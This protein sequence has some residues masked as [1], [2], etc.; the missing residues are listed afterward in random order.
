MSITPCPDADRTISRKS[1]HQRSDSGELDVFEAAR[2]FSGYGDVV[3]GYDATTLV[4]KAA[5]AR[6]QEREANSRGGG[7]MSLDVPTK[8]QHHHHQHH[9]VDAHQHFHLVP[10]ENK[11]TKE[12]SKITKPRQPSSPGG[13]L[14]SFLNSL[15]S[16]SSSKKK[17]S[18]S[19]PSSTQS[20]K[21][22]DESPGWRRRRR[23]S[24]SHFRSS[25]AVADSKSVYTSLSSG[26]KTPPA[27]ILNTP[28]KSYKEFRSYSD[29]KQVVVSKNNRDGK[30]VKAPHLGNDAVSGNKR[31]N[32]LSWLDEKFK[33]I[34]PSSEKKKKGFGNNGFAKHASESTD[35]KRFD[36]EEED[37]GAQSD[38]SSDLFELQ[39]YDLGGY[40]SSGLPVYETTC[41]ESIKRGSS[42]T[43]TTVS[44]AAF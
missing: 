33:L 3:S 5:M 16:Q 9:Q 6:G 20:M 39:N 32:D 38:S 30:H 21:D 10:S 14:A 37:D 2:Y 18:S 36:E 41:I 27:Y 44:G 19:K 1:L 12:K 24:I 22:E 11:Q 4:Q 8:H 29:H 28:T 25:S 13:R 40:C 15:F 26:S 42:T 34:E 43:A 35:V 17:K 7:R 31:S 23:S